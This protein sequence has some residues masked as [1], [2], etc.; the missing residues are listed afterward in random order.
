MKTEFYSEESSQMSDMQKF[1][2][3]PMGA[4]VERGKTLK[5][6]DAKKKL[7]ISRKKLLFILLVVALV[8]INIIVIFYVLNDGTVPFLNIKFGGKEAVTKTFFNY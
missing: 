3:P 1:S 5:R 8:I 4:V 7:G 2:A 6:R